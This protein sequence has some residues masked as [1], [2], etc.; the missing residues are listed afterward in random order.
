MQE[1]VING[2]MIQAGPDSPKKAQCPDC[3]DAVTKRR[4]R[5]MDGSVSWFY[6]HNRGE[7]DGCLRRY[8]PVGTER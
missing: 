4:R 5:R 2:Q 6:R 1:A 8:I 7:G 3:G